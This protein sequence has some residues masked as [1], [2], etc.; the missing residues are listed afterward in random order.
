MLK[1]LTGRRSTSI[2]LVSAIF[3]TLTLTSCSRLF[4]ALVY[5]PCV[6]PARVSFGLATAVRWYS[7]TTV[8]PESAV[9][10]AN[11]MDASSGTVDQVRVVFGEAPQAVLKVTVGEDDPVPVLNPVAMC[12]ES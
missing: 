11:V 1:R 6:Q 2:K 3:A 12:P 9:R 10:V 7:E 4:D 5:N 8:P